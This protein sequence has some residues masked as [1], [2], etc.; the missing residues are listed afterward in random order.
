MLERIGT[1]VSMALL[2]LAGG[3]TLA[4]PDRDPAPAA[5]DGVVRNPLPRWREGGT[6]PPDPNQS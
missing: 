6:P 3:T 2:L 5:W 4:G 1:V